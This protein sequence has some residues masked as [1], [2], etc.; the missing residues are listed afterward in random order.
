MIHNWNP[1]KWLC[2]SLLTG[3]L[4]MVSVHGGESLGIVGKND[5]LFLRSK[6]S[7]SAEAAGKAETISLIGCLNKVFSA[8][9]ISMIVTMM[10]AKVRL[11]AEFL[12]DNIKLND[13]MAGN[14]DSMSKALQ[15]AGVT[16]IDL[17]TPF[18][19]SPLRDSDPHLNGTTLRKY[20][21]KTT[22]YEQPL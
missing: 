6:L 9:G 11:Y 17:N 8:N 2:C 10:P 7:G 21:T 22:A 19:N 14:Y 1:S 20:P 18:M 4:G 3:A 12:P 15:A 13:Y 16:L 5:W